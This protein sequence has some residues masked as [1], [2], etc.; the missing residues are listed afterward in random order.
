MRE[1]LRTA[2]S[3]L[4]TVVMKRGLI[5]LLLL[6]S[7][8]GLSDAHSITDT[9]SI[10]INIFQPAAGTAAGNNLKVVVFISST[11]EIKSVKASVEGRE[12]ELA[13]SNTGWSGNVSLSGLPRGQKT[14]TVIATDAFGNTSQAQRI[15]VYDQAPTLSITA[16]LA[17]TVARPGIFVDATCA[18]DD[19][20]GCASLTV[21]V[22]GETLAT[23]KDAVR[24]SFSL[25]S[26]D[27][28]SPALTF[29][30]RDSIGQ[31]TTL[32]RPIFVESSTNLSEVVS[33]GGRI[34]DTQSDRILFRENE[35]LKIRYRAS[36]LDTL[37]TSDPARF[38][39]YGFLA[40]KGAI[41]MSDSGPLDAT[42]YDWRDGNLVNLGLLNSSDSLKVKGKYA[43][44]NL[45]PPLPSTSLI[46]RDLDSGVNTQVSTSAG[47]IND[48]LSASGDVVYW[49]SDSSTNYNVYRYR[50]G[51]NT[52]LTNDSSLWNSY[53]LTDGI[54]V[55]YRKHTPCCGGQTYA[56]VLY[57]S[58]G[59]VTL[60]APRS[61]EPNP[62]SDYQLNGG[63]VTFTRL[64]NGPL[65]VWTRSPAAEEAQ[66][67]FYGT[68]SFIKA[69]SPFGGVIFNHDGRSYLK[70]ANAPTIDVGSNLGHYFW[71]DGQWL[72]TIGRSLFRVNTTPSP[73]PTL[74]TET[75]SQQAVAL[76]AVTWARSPFS[77]ITT[78]NFSSDQRTRVLLL[79]TNVSLLPGDNTGAITA[80][81]EDSQHRLYSLPV[82]YVGTILNF[83]WLT[84][85]NV[86]LPE[87]LRGVGNVWLSITVRGEVSNRVMINIQ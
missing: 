20:A 7:A 5:A 6:C 71:Q 87:E 46:L 32:T 57:T 56:I 75:D 84:Q 19:P 61:Q 72:V 1:F 29:T 86:T 62:G 21:S 17:E 41:F 11:L 45:S 8:C 31:T 36:G 47:N 16:P 10:D 78:Q 3:G 74:L 34:L 65:Q 51:A 81:A 63:W 60:S 24:G 42:V 49:S 73:V 76:N 53:P 40:P 69:L 26:H 22:N 48:D 35:S 68:S 43:I 28:Q 14:L 83:D 18:D 82:E 38:I 12:A 58:A 33:V 66:I 23:G 70:E 64:G 52:K 50:G 59:E 79:A 9:P 25:S 44:W 77:T 2:L 15:F 85:I 39:E 80:Q 13:F 55:A 30:A 37:V 27:G 67:T 4:P 54:N